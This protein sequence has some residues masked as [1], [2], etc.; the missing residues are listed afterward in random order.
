MN[1]SDALEDN[2]DDDDVYPPNNPKLFGKLN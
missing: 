1:L 2:D